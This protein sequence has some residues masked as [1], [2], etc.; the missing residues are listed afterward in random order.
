MRRRPINSG[1]QRVTLARLCRD[2]RLALG[3]SQQALA[4]RMGV[5]RSYIT[6]IERSRANPSLE[7]VVRLAT[8]LGFE[9]DLMAQRPI[10]VGDRRQ[11]DAVHARCSGYV[12]RR[13]TA[14]GWE[15]AREVELIEG[16]WR[17][18]IDLLAFDRRTGT[19]LVIE[20]KTRIDDVGALE[21]QIGWYE[22]SARRI[23]R[24]RGWN[25]RRVLTWLLVL[26]SDEV[27]ASLVANRDVMARAFPG[28]AD[29]MTAVVTGDGASAGA[30]ASSPARCLAAIDPSRRRRIWLLPTRLDRRRGATP[31][32]DYRDAAER[33]GAGRRKPLD[34]RSARSST[35]AQTRSA[36]PPH[37][38]P[39]PARS[40]RDRHSE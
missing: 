20:I 19:L 31:Y 26:A 36:E 11:R 10:V 39:G 8:T 21:R 6:A 15:T 38:A 14:D 24:T 13:L 35:S 23:A 27:E 2:G 22:R 5:S 30:G 17:G 33:V 18:W 3:W 25:V 1:P 32:R 12:D 40:S 29:V 34:T 16:R 9:I 28:R 7:V 37:S 4:T